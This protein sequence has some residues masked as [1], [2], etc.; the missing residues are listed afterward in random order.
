MVR[1]MFVGSFG[2]VRFC[3]GRDN[4]ARRNDE[5]RDNL[6]PREQ[7]DLDEEV[8]HGVLRMNL[9]EATVK[10]SVDNS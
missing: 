4:T 5:R 2:G 10:I 8:L 1:R 7:E 3:G 6:H 9:S